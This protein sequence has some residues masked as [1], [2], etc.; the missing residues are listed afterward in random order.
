MNFGVNFSTPFTLKTDEKSE[1]LEKNVTDENIE[2]TT[3]NTYNILYNIKSPAVFSS[4]ITMNFGKLELSLDMKMQNW[5][6]MEFESDLSDIDDDGNKTSTDIRINQN[7]RKYLKTTTDYGIGISIP[8]NN[9]ILLNTGYRVISRP[10]YDLADD[11]QQVHLAGIGFQIK[12]LNIIS[13]GIT[14]QTE[15]GKQTIEDTYFDTS[16][17][18]KYQNHKI[19]F[20]TSLI[21]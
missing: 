15:I 14:Y 2:I 6:N 9:E 13:L 10:F 7:I 16:T 1:I 3:K 5:H 17:F 19:I 20:S 12:L 4:G 18:Q 11:E 8:I 21:L